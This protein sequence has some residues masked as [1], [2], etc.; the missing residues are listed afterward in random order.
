MDCRLADITVH[1][2]TF[3]EGRPLIVLP[4]WNHDWRIEADIMEP[5]QADHEFLGRLNQHEAMS[6][7]V[8][9]L[10]APFLGPSLSCSRGR[11]GSSA[12]R[13]P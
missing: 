7:G 4:A 10:A 8:D 9:Q 3:G 2:E 13:R 5:L 12:I 11:T 1:Y 6:F